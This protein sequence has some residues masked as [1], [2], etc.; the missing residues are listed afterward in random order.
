[1]AVLMSLLSGCVPGGDAL[2]GCAPDRAVTFFCFAKRKS[3]KK[4]RAGFVVPTLRYGHAALLGPGGVRV[5]SLRS[6]IRAPFSAQ[7]CATRLLITAEESE[8]RIQ[9]GRA[10]ARPCLSLAVDFR[11]FGFLC[12]VAGLSSAAAGGSGRALFERSEFSPTPPDASS[13]RHRAAALTAAA[14]SFAYFSLGKQRKVSR[15]PGRDPAPCAVGHT[16]RHPHQ[17]C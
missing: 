15:P 1:L 12:R 9:Q 3:P 6:N 2:S 10:M 7:S 13:A 14:F 11:P 16:S 17:P 8:Y 5:N 4:R